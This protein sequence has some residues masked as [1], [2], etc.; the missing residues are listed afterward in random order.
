[1]NL[2]GVKPSRM[3]EI[4]IWKRGWDMNFLIGQL[5]YAVEKYGRPLSLFVDH[6]GYS[7]EL[8]AQTKK[9]VFVQH[10]KIDLRFLRRALA[11]GRVIVYVDYFYLRRYTHNPHF[12]V[13]NRVVGAKFE[14]EDPGFGTRT[15]VEAEKL[16]RAIVGLRN[17]LF[18][19]PIVI[20]LK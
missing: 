14:I 2:F 15:L 4:E 19:S 1:M 8:K 12:I 13:V 7:R 6:A 16:G 9:D 3:K 20:S 18:F 10:A 17:H 11:C 5:N